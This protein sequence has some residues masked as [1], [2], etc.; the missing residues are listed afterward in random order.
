MLFSVIATHK[1][2]TT[3]RGIVFREMT[4][5][6]ILQKIKRYREQMGKLLSMQL[7]LAAIGRYIFRFFPPDVAQQGV[8]GDVWFAEDYIYPNHWRAGG[9]TAAVA[10]GTP[11]TWYSWWWKR[12]RGRAVAV[13][14]LIALMWR[15]FTNKS[16]W[17]DE[18]SF[19][20]L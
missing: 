6:E 2:L 5:Q 19:D 4:T 16:N 8:T 12:N 9:E 18:Y 1:D 17:W 3:T 13:A 10:I 20:D 7:I 15:Y 14:V 11:Q